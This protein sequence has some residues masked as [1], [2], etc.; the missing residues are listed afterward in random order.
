VN[1]RP[2]FLVGAPR[3]GT[4]LLRDLLRSHPRITF[5]GESHFIPL[6]YQA[7]GDPHS[8]QEAVRLARKILALRW[9]RRW[10][11]DLRA[12][13][14]GDCRSYREVVERLYGEWAQHEG[15]ERW[16]DKTPQYATQIDAL[17]SL[18]PGSQFLHIYRDGRDEA[19]SILKAGFGPQNV[20]VA[21]EEWRKFVVAARRSGS[22]LPAGCYH[23]VRYEELVATPEPIL[24]TVL[25][26]LGED[27]HPAVLQPNFLERDVRTRFLGRSPSTTVARDRIVSANFGKWRAQMQNRDQRHFEALAGDLLAELGYESV[28]NRQPLSPLQGWGWRLHHSLFWAL[29]RLNMRSKDPATAWLLLCAKLQSLR[30]RRPR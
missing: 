16:G 15:K 20:F 22:R 8:E 1:R 29:Q 14:F 10:G 17:H 7:Y 27:Y 30:R 3:S 24:R 26:F 5:P 2:I 18:F 19:L 9:V 21:A 4:A 6:F 11:L 28:A 25:A 23:E 12:S 13:Q